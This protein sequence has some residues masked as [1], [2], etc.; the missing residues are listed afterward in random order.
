MEEEKCC[1]ICLEPDERNNLIAPCLCSGT[2]K[3]VHRNCLNQW[4]ITKED[5]AFSR[6]TECLQLYTFFPVEEDNSRYSSRLRFIGYCIIDIIIALCVIFIVTSILGSIVYGIDKTEYLARKFEVDGEVEGNVILFYYGCGVFISL[7]IVGIIYSIMLCTGTAGP[8]AENVSCEGCCEICSRNT[9]VPMYIRGGSSDNC[10]CCCY[11]CRGC[12]TC[13]GCEGGCAACDGACAGASCE[14]EALIFLL[15]GLVIFAIIG[16]IVSFIFGIILIQKVANRHVHILQKKSIVDQYVVKDLADDS[17]NYNHSNDN[18]H[19]DIEL[20]YLKKNPLL[21]SEEE[22]T[23]STH[24]ISLHTD[25]MDRNENTRSDS[26][27][28]H[29]T[30]RQQ[31]ELNRLGFL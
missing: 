7:T 4:R 25:L 23:S 11:N 20:G 27:E 31:E 24:D 10:C 9:Y 8:W 1:R 30:R 26:Y 22:S 16:L 28:N 12:V 13:E 3:W 18:N 17:N 5:K 2:Q 21:S 29:M 15:I 14:Q 19:N 6:C